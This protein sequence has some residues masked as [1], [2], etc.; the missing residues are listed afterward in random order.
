MVLVDEWSNHKYPTPERVT[1]LIRC[2]FP[3]EELE[4]HGATADS[5]VEE[6]FLKVTQHEQC[7]VFFF[8]DPSH[9][10]CSASSILQIWNYL[11]LRTAHYARRVK[12]ELVNMHCKGATDRQL[13]DPAFREAICEK[14]GEEDVNFIGRRLFHRELTASDRRWICLVVGPAEIFARCFFFSSS[15]VRTLSTVLLLLLLFLSPFCLQI[16]RWKKCLPLEAPSEAR[17]CKRPWDD[18]QDR[19]RQSRPINWA[20]LENM[21]AFSDI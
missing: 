5:L 9:A 19:P 17:L 12:A 6:A 16:Y 18:M 11:R 8:S 20:E 3:Q 13:A 7:V 1:A 15:D 14:V 10:F 2:A 21:E 4:Q